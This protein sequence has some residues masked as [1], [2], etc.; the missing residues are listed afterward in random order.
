MSKFVET[1]DVETVIW[2]LTDEAIGKAAH[3]SIEHVDWNQITV[4]LQN[5]VHFSLCFES[6]GR[7]T[8]AGWT[9]KS[10]DTP[11]FDFAIVE[12]DGLAVESPLTK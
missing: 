11:V 4:R 7:I 1:V 8:L 10:G 3:V 2:Q 6:D 12:S 9:N 5:G